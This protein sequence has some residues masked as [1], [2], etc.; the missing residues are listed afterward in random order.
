[1]STIEEFPVSQDTPPDLIARCKVFVELTS[2]KRDLE[3][4][5]R[6]IQ[7]QLNSIE[8]K[9]IEDM[10]LNGM[11]GMSID[12]MTVYR[13]TDWYARMKEGVERADIVQAFG[14]AGLGY[15][16]SLSWQTLKAQAREWAEEE[17]KMPDLVKQFC[18][19]GQQTRL[20]CR[21]Q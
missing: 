3:Q 21:K 13:S 19:I 9:A 14:D 8:E 6:A 16:L 5:L 20:R 17:E 4:Q 7:D 11:Q 18:E 1:M 12:G 2:A 10:A 15:L